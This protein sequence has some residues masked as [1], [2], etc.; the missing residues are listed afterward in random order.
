MS[1]RQPDGLVVAGAFNT[2]VEAV[3]ARGALEAVGIE[4]MLQADSVGHMRAHVAWSTGGFKVLVRNEDLEDALACLKTGEPMPFF[5][6]FHAC[7]G[8]EDAVAAAIAEV[9]PLSR[10]EPGCVSIQGFRSKHD[11]RL[12]HVHSLWQDE[13]AFELHATLPHTVRFLAQIEPLLDQPA[14]FARSERIA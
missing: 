9:M 3:L 13:G 1:G 6:R 7:A 5:A 8:Q 12:F 4:A 10:A 14:E 2:E 11:P